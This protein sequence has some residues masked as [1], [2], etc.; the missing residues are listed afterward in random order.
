MT[1]LAE[2]IAGPIAQL[3][4]SRPYEGVGALAP[5]IGGTKTE[6]RLEHDAHFSG[7][8]FNRRDRGDGNH[9]LLLGGR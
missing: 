1:D 8:F 4:I 9:Q 7:P 6:Q 2:R 3:T 5:T